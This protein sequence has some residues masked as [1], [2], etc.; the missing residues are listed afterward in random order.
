MIAKKIYY[1]KKLCAIIVNSSIANAGTGKKGLEDVVFYILS[2]KKSIA[3]LNKYYL[4][5]WCNYGI[6]ANK[7]NGIRYKLP[8]KRLILY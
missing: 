7:E 1:V 3:I 4:F 2:C 5:S 6:F 8:C